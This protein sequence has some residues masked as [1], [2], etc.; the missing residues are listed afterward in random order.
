MG[1]IKRD[2]TLQHREMDMADAGQVMGIFM[3]LTRIPGLVA[4]E[5]ISDH[6]VAAG[7]HGYLGM[8]SEERCHPNN[9]HEES[10]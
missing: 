3:S 2:A 9:R 10:Q 8:D 4:K 5:T 1:L 6:S 7:T